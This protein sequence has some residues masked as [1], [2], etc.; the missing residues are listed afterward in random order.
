MCFRIVN[1]FGTFIKHLERKGSKYHLHQ[2]DLLTNDQ[3]Y[4]QLKVLTLRFT[5]NHLKQAM[6]SFHGEK[7]TPSKY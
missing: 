1:D 4:A 3:R 6:K 7:L 2:V 5:I